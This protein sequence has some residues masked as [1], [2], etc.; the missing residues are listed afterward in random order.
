MSQSY[1]DLTETN[2]PQAIDTFDRATDITIE[3][4]PL[5]QEYQKLYNSG[6]INE[7]SKI[8]IDHPELQSCMINAKTINRCYDG[9]KALQR[10]YFSD[11]QKYLEQIIT[12]KGDYSNKTAYKKYDVCLYNNGS[13][14]LCISDSK[15]GS[16]P[17]DT[18]YFVPLTLQGEQ[19][20]AGI[21]LTFEGSWDAKAT[22]SSDSCVT[23]NNV[24]YASLTDDNLAKTPS[25][26]SSYWTVVIDFDLLTTYDNSSSGLNSVSLQN[27]I[28]EVNAKVNTSKNNISTNASNITSNTNKI[29]D[30]NSRISNI[31]NTPDN[32]KHVKNADTVDGVHFHPGDTS[33]APNGYGYVYGFAGGDDINAWVYPTTQM[34]V[35]YADSAGSAT[36]ASTC[37]GNSVTATSANYATNAGNSDSVDGFHFQ[38]GT[39]DLTAG[40]SSLATNVFYFVYE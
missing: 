1:L 28:D 16:L 33:G 38:L 15:I 24:L 9:I 6:K 11:I 27:A 2:F 12:Y 36:T 21:N 8:L 29:A 17:T 20:I 19:G 31:D 34:S 5:V 22:Y 30:I 40:S 10:Y 32:Q 14:Y 3:L 23:Y 13:A 18:S 26:T 35:K 25:K 37:T 7:A 39:T 4:L